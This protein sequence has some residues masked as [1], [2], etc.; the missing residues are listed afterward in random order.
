MSPEISAALLSMMGALVVAGMTLA[1]GR[2]SNLAEIDHTR[3]NT[4]Q[5][6]VVTAVSAAAAI[7]EVSAENSALRAQGDETRHQLNDVLDANE[8]H[9]RWDGLM[10]KAL[11]SLTDAL[12][13]HGIVA[14][15]GD[16]PDPP[17]LARRTIPRE[18]PT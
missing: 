13:T 18:S 1:F 15:V 5:I 14:D 9:E 3:A 4:E 2:R 16:L 12:A 11:R 17:P 8:D 6:H 7:R 10:V